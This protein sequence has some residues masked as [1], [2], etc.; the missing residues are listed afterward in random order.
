[1]LD[2]KLLRSD[3]KA[4]ASALKKRGF[5]LDVNAFT[6]LEEE[7]KA[8][9]I[10][11]ESLQQERNSR[12]KN[13]GKAKASGEDI[14]PLLKEVE[15]LKSQLAQADDELKSIQEKMD[16]LL[17]SVPNL[18][19]DEVPEGKDEDDNVEVRRWGTPREFDFDVKDHVDLGAT[20][21]DG[22]QGLDFDV[23]SKLTGS[24]FAVMRGGIAR[25]HRAL[26]Q[27]MINTHIEE[28]GYQEIYVPYMV[29]KDSLFGTGQLPK[30]EEDL[31]KTNDEREL[32]LIPTAEVPVTNILRNELLQDGQ[33]L[34][35]KLV[36]HTPC[37]RS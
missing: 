11:T 36:C 8:V 17:A 15:S 31:F 28:H 32:Y 25:L 29:N 34:P 26:I 21:G 12:S 9:Q 13:I 18:P 30:F 35:L 2:P 22:Y 3:P 20:I 37:F 7:R 27:F 1:M 14:A 6:A 19:A 4:V 16:A 24:R 5:E 23:A 10:K 33:S